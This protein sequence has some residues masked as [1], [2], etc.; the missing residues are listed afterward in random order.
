MKDTL[1]TLKVAVAQAAPVLFDK[2]ATL[3]KLT[4]LVQKAAGQG[5]SLV[6]FPES[7]L[8]AY[9]RGFSYGF[10]VGSRTMEGR[11]DFKRYYDGSVIVP[12]RDTDII[13]SA[14]REYGV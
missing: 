5:A 8:P 1:K 11:L 14:A 4:L 3:E 13:A 7:F 2:E 10:V 6:V 9:P 12:S